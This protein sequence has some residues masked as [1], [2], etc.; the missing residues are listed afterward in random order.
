MIKPCQKDSQLTMTDE[1]VWVINLLPGSKCLTN[2]MQLLMDLLDYGTGLAGIPNFD[3]YIQL[4]FIFIHF[5]R[6]A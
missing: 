3:S 6:R 2:F 4:L 5:L 1:L